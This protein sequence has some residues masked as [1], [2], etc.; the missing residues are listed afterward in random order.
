MLFGVSLAADKQPAH[1]AQRRDTGLN[2]RIHGLIEGNA[3]FFARL[4]C[5]K[6]K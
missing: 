6:P 5:I 1:D 3:G 4:F 2:E